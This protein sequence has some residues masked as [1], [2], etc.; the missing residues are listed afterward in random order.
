MGI[1][2]FIINQYLLIYL[3]GMY[4]IQDKNQRYVTCLYNQKQRILH[5]RLQAR[6]TYHKNIERHTAHT[7]VSWPDPEQWVTIHTSDLI[8]II[9]QSIYILSI[10]TREMGELK[11]HSLTYCI[12]DNWENMP[13]LT[14]LTKYIWQAFYKFHVFR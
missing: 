8:M 3:T 1:R 11:T 2:L 5:K 4:T 12:M 7:I 13:Y 10:I 14:H 9:R 6:F